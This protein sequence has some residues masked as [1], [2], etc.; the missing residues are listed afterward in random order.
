MGTISGSWG[1]VYCVK[2]NVR[3]YEELTP[4]PG[5]SELPLWADW[6]EIKN[7]EILMPNLRTVIPLM[8][9][10]ITNFK[11]IDEGP[12]WKS[13]THEYKIVVPSHDNRDGVDPVDRS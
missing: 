1:V 6:H 12:D 13:D 7:H 2:I 11:V 9:A 4:G 3:G 10:G 8:K 5:E